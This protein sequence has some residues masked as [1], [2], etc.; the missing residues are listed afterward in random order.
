MVKLAQSE[1]QGRSKPLT[2]IS[3][4]LL[5][6]AIS[7]LATTW[8][9]LG[10]GT[11]D[12]IVLKSLASGRY[13]G[14]PEYRLMYSTPI[15]GFLMRVLFRS[16]PN[17]DW[18]TFVMFLT[19]VTA[20]TAIMTS[21][22]KKQH[23]SLQLIII[24]VGFVLFPKFLFPMQFT[25]AAVL[26]SM[27]GLT[28]IL[29]QSERRPIQR[30]YVGFI[31]LSLGISI[32]LEAGLLVM[33]IFFIPLLLS[34]WEGGHLTTRKLLSAVYPIFGAVLIN[35]SV[36]QFNYPIAPLHSLSGTLIKIHSQQSEAT[37]L[38]QL[39]STAHDLFAAT[40]GLFWD[41][42]I[43]FEEVTN[44]RFKGDY[45][46]LLSLQQTFSILLSRPYVIF[47]SIFL[48]FFFF[49]FSRGF[50]GNLIG[51]LSVGL[52]LIGFFGASTYLYGAY[53]KLPYRLLM[54][55]WAALIMVQMTTL[56]TK[57]SESLTTR[58]QLRF[59]LF[60]TSFGLFGFTLK[61]LQATIR[62]LSIFF[63]LTLGVRYLTFYGARQTEVQSSL[64]TKFEI[65]KCFASSHR[66]IFAMYPDYAILPG[67]DL[68]SSN[69]DGLYDFPIFDNGWFLHT[70]LFRKRLEYFK[71]E[72]N[73]SIV[74][75]LVLNNAVV[76]TQR[77][78]AK[79]LADL[80][81]EENPNNLVDITAISRCDVEA[82]SLNPAQG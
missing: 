21:L 39:S 81:N 46:I 8:L 50:K 38:P 82:Y 76:I 24:A 41:R 61:K 55:L 27:A 54:P 49:F 70:D 62:V 15:F 30:R 35:L 74:R 59:R 51:A 68:V 67:G 10:F 17:Y 75:M 45:S 80:H 48:F 7:Y 47:L 78:T 34:T 11:N 36:N 16:F 71:L 29:Q 18:Y 31:L 9:P 20:M 63:F 64:D 19:Q 14:Q 79:L 53:G 40:V 42:E 26:A 37:D 77:S 6:L 44:S 69:S 23:K 52:G 4:P 12:D 60:P 72:R 2:S 3:V 5:L 56:I 65:T 43:A 32:R 25:G 22:L 73:D 13:L 28:L 1:I 57:T 33:G 66:M 58:A